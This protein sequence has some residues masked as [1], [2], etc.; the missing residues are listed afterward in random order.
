MGQERGFLWGGGGVVKW[1]KHMSDASDDAFIEGLEDKFGWE[2]Y[3]RWWKLLEIIARAMDK[4]NEPFAVH[5]WVKWSLFLKGKQNKLSLF[6]VHCQNEGRITLEQNGNILKIICPKLLELRD[7]HSRRS[8]VT[9]ERTREKLPPK[10]ESKS[11][12]LDKDTLSSERVVRAREPWRDKNNLDIHAVGLADVTPHLPSYAADHQLELELALETWREHRRTNL[13]TK[14]DWIADA[15]GWLRRELASI[16]RPP[17][18]RMEFS[19]ENYEARY[20]R[21]IEEIEKEKQGA[22]YH[23]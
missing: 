19:E 8:G 1:F 15:A 17:P 16:K 4:N 5:S 13:Q 11:K 6:L 14:P 2:G 23:A 20:Q 10:R 18:G 7:E 3:G 22:T 9:T 21:E 12:E